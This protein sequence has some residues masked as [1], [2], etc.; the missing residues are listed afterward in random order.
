MK[1]DLIVFD[2]DGTLTDT[3]K[4][5]VRWCNDMNELYGFKLAKINENNPLTVRSVLGTPM[6]TIIQNYG[7]PVDKIEELVQRYEREF[8]ANDK[9][10]ANPF[11]DA[12]VLLDRLSTMSTMGK[13]RLGLVSSNVAENIQRDLGCVDLFDE[14]IDKRILDDKGWNKSDALT[15]MKNYG[16]ESVCPVYVGDTMKDFQAARAAEFDFIGVTYG[17]EIDDIHGINHGFQI[18]GSIDELATIL[19]VR[20]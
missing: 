20:L 10:A 4:T 16:G 2:V 1:Y 6:K 12:L 7:F 14:C 9:Y 3:G 19:N 17:W 8:G 11:P 5:H 13:S 15:F 18:A